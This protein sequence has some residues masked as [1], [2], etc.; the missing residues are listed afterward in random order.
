MCEEFEILERLDAIDCRLADIERWVGP[1]PKTRKIMD[2]L[3]EE[4]RFLESRVISSNKLIVSLL[5]RGDAGGDSNPTR[6]D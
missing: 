5:N 1:R 4:V 2:D 3:R 6:D